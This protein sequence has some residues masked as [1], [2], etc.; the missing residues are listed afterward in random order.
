MTVKTHFQHEQAL[1][2][3]SQI[4]E[5][6]RIWAFT[7][8]LPQAVIGK[9][10]NICDHVFI[11]NDVAIGDRVTIKCGVQIWDGITLEDD[12][13][14]G[15]NVTFTN[16]IFPRSKVYPSTFSKTVVRAGASIGANAT[17]LPGITIHAKAMIGAGAVVVDDVPENA[18]VVGN[19]AHIIGYVNEEKKHS[20]FNQN[21]LTVKNAKLFSLPLIKDLRGSLSFAEIDAHLPFLPK[22]YFIV[23]DVPSKKIRGEH[24]HK[25]LEEVLICLR[26]S[27]MVSLDDRIN[28][29][30]VFLDSAQ[31]A[32][33]IPPMTW[34]TQ[35]QYSSDALLLVLASD[36][37]KENDYIRNY[38]E[39]K[40]LTT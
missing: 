37:Y 38:H 10:C 6:T 11:E 35:Y 13:F 27:C 36:V 23:F 31:K 15:P 7:H 21:D 2:E 39:F 18:I 5:G 4:G 19:P 30:N 12:V 14:V 40:K 8:I 34:S 16:D 1:V 25:E 24:A 22:R 26:G 33:Y 3:S 17:I 20:A 28:Q 29:D 9:D 32:L